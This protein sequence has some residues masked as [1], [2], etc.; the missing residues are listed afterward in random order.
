MLAV[1]PAR[2]G[3]TRLPAKPLL[4][5]GGQPLIWRV[6]EA[7]RT[8]QAIDE[9]VVATDDERILK[10]VTDLGGNCQMTDPNHQS[11]TDRVAEISAR[12]PKYEYILNVQGDE[13][14]I[15]TQQL[16]SVIALLAKDRAQIGTMARP[17]GQIDQILSQQVVKVVMNDAREAL[18]FSR[19][20]IPF[21]RDLDQ[22]E[23]VDQHAHYQHLG[24]YG[25]QREV[26]SSL[27]KLEV[28]TLEQAEKLEQLRWLQAA[29]KIKVALTDH[30]GM[31]ID[32]PE[33]L[34]TARQIFK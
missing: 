18:Y 34:E 24:L 10:A 32:T 22:A 21:I 31:G 19:S 28:S 2:Y 15:Q 3:S 27:T 30:V 26:L 6:Y 4:D 11:G 8:C 1:I 7:V 25:F 20:P 16:Q 33:D 17:L 12:L 29:F 13:P 5:L 23:W 9:V 14:F